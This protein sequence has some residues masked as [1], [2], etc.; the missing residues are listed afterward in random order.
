MPILPPSAFAFC[1]PTYLGIS[2]VID[3]ER[4]I[5]LFPELEIGSAKSQIALIG[6]PGMSATP[7]IT[8]PTSPLQA[9][10]VGA[11]RLFVV[12][13]A[14][15]RLRIIFSARAPSGCSGTARVF[16]HWPHR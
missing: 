6:R 1:G 15:V 16:C 12:S 8:L 4:S 5:N 2:P 11:N 10:W 13:G 14:T 7:F 3:A 9:F